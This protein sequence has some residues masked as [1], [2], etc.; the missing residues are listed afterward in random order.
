M[1][2]C[3]FC[4]AT[5]EP[6]T[7]KMYILKDGTVYH[8][9]S[10]KCQRNQIALGRTGRLEK[11]TKAYHAEHKEAKHGEAKAAVKTE[12]KPATPQQ[13]NAPVSQHA[14]KPAHS[15]TSSR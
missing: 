3:T 5:L 9:C 11:W 7:G 13:T 6:G 2:R 10:S 4:R 12:S 14:S 15:A 1:A 8:F